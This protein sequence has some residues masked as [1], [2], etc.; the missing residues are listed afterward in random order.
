[1]CLKTSFMQLTVPAASY[2][3]PL[4]QCCFAKTFADL[5]SGVTCRAANQHQLSSAAAS[6]RRLGTGGM[7]AL[8][9]GSEDNPNQKMSWLKSSG[10]TSWSSM[11][12]K[13]AYLTIQESHDFYKSHV[14]SSIFLQG[15]NSLI[16]YHSLYWENQYELL[17]YGSVAFLIRS[18]VLEEGMNTV[19]TDQKRLNKFYK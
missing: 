1:M 13:T 7:K 9:S 2:I 10:W 18:V 11:E 12:T 15:S 5:S 4:Q 8:S 16:L 3:T 17:T 19:V 14:D 6:G